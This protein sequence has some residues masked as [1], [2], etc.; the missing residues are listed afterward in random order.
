MSDWALVLFMFIF[1]VVGSIT[2]ILMWVEVY[3]NDEDE[4]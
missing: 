3:D 2:A 4:E 1:L